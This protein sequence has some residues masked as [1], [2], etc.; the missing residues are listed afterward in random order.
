[1][2][3]QKPENEPTCTQ[4]QYD[5]IPEALQIYTV[6][7]ENLEGIMFTGLVQMFA[8]KKKWQILIWR[9]LYSII[10]SGNERNLSVNVCT[11][12]LH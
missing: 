1:M 11:L 5:C 7:P 8:Y 12:A 4:E 9:L 2:H 6:W 10:R 3:S